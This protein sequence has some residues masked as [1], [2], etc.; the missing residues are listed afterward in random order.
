MTEGPNVFVCHRCGACCRQPGYVHLRE[1]ELYAIANFLKLTVSTFTARYTRLTHA[2]GGLSLKEKP[3]G[4]CIFLSEHG[5]CGIEAV[6]PR[7]CRQ[8]PFGWRYRD[9]GAICPAWREYEK[10][11]T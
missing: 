9:I 5:S 3:N 10:R 4:A 7:Q 6:K 2:R 8:F 11:N 1:A